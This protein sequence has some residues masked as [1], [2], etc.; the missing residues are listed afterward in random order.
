MTLG[1]LGTQ[2]PISQGGLVLSRVRG[3]RLN[4]GIP[5]EVI[6]SPLN[7]IQRYLVVNSMHLRE[8]SHG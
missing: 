6:V 3:P 7:E 1:T 5:A 2:S 8:T 4:A